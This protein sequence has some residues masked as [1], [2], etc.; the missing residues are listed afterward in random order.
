MNQKILTTI[1]HITGV[2]L[3]ASAVGYFV[4][5]RALAEET[6][7]ES[8]LTSGE[9]AHKTAGGHCGIPGAEVYKNQEPPTERSINGSL[10]PQ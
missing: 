9:P 8:A 6:S 10:E 2:I 7:E 4:F 3:I 5:V 1:A